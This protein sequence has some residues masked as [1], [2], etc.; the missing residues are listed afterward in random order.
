MMATAKWMK[1]L[2]KKELRH[3]AEGNA[4]GRPTLRSLRAN[5]LSQ[6]TSGATCFECES[7]ARKLS[8]FAD[9]VA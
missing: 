1:K 2:T 6:R 9:G 4:T 3:L 7:I 8:L 5:I